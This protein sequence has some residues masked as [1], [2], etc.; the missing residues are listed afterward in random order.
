MKALLMISCSKAGG[1]QRG[2]FE[3]GW[4]PEPELDVW[5]MGK[6]GVTLQQHQCS[7][8]ALHPEPSDAALQT[9]QGA[10]EPQQRP[11]S[12]HVKRQ[13]CSCL[14]IRA[15]SETYSQPAS[16]RAGLGE[17]DRGK[18]EACLSS[19]P[20]EGLVTL[21]CL[22]NGNHESPLPSL[23]PSIPSQAPGGAAASI[24]PEQRRL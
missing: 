4:C 6:A 7:G 12:C 1:E 24:N 23:L 10:Q 22:L 8:P 5:W 14:Q 19:A 13:Q 16:P 2:V 18:S 17:T 15:W 20:Q 11:Q 9:A 21:C 3:P